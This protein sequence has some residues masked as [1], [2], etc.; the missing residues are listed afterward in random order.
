MFARSL[1]QGRSALRANQSRNFATLVLSE[2][3][4]G[5]LNP[6]LGSVLNAASQLNDSQVD[7]LVCGDNTDA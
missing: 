1:M 3:F 7:V 2:H 4:E 6:S 5:K